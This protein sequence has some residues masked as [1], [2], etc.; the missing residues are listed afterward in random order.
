M[1]FKLNTSKIFGA[2]FLVGVGVNADNL[3]KTTDTTDNPCETMPV[4]EAQIACYA[5]EVD[6]LLKFP[7]R[8]EDRD[9][10][11]EPAGILMG[12]CRSNKENA[13]SEL[14][15]AESKL[16]RAKLAEEGKILKYKKEEMAGKVAAALA[17]AAAAAAEA[18]LEAAEA[19]LEAAEEAFNN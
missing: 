3:S 17:A 13:G 6:H 4:G 8:Q 15:Q 19:A 14:R 5:E 12:I 1:V 16:R 7:P 11:K 18:A 9:C 10:S 2:A